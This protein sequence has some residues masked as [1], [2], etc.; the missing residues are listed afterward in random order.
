MIWCQCVGDVL[1]KLCCAMSDSKGIINHRPLILP[2]INDP[3]RGT[4]HR[5]RISAIRISITSFLRGLPLFISARP[6]SPLRVL[7]MMAFDTVHRFRTSK[8]LPTDRLRMLAV[9]L[10][11][12]AAANVAFD[13]KKESCR[14]EFHT[15]RT[16]LDDAGMS[17]L[18]TEFLSRLRELETN[19]PSPERDHGQFEKMKSYRE[20]VVRLSLSM[21]ATIAFGRQSIDDE[22]QATQSDDELNLLFRIA[23][24]CQ[25]IDDV[26]DSSKDAAAGLPSFLTAS[27]SL[28]QALELTLEAALSY[29]DVQVVR[30]SAETFPLRLALSAVSE[31]ARLV[32]ALGRWRQRISVPGRV[33]KHRPFERPVDSLR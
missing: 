26:L 4:V 7:C 18:V 20:A 33:S 28:P 17:A 3:V 31:C 5:G 21:V 9:C 12:E 32:I 1:G 27:T 2:A 11:F 6:Q 19:R 14:N 29:A 16:L 30:H 15:T 8:Q 22:I 10:D 25:I 13:N 23:M 24:Q